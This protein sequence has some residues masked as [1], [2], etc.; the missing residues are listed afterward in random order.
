MRDQKRRRLA[1]SHQQNKNPI[2]KNQLKYT[3]PTI[4]SLIN[5]TKLGDLHLAE[6]H[7]VAVRS[8]LMEDQNNPATTDKS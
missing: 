4:Y 6:D 5:H 1:A 3:E 7:A 8:N 2:K